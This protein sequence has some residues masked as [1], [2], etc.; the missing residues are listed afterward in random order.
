MSWTL[1]TSGAA[2]A[3]AG[4]NAN[5]V[6]VASGAALALFSDESE[7]RICAETN[8]DWIAGFANVNTSIKQALSRASAADVAM[9][10]INYDMGGFTS[11]AEA[12]TMLSVL[13]NDYNAIIKELKKPDFNSL[14]NP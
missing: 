9:S 14:R 4:A 2:I 8:V 13:D 11:R 10:I 12:Q 7:G 6:I 3:R 5:S 1:T